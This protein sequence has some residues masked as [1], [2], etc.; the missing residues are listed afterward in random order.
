MPDYQPLDLSRLCNAGLDFIGDD[1]RPAIGIQEFHGLPFLVADDPARCFIAFGGAG[2]NRP[3]VTV[4]VGQTARR[5]LFAHA[6]LE[7]TVLE[8]D[9]VGRVVAGYVVRYA[10]GETLRIEVRERFEI[11]VIPP[12]QGGGRPF[13]AMTDQPESLRRRR[14]DDRWDAAGWR[15]TEA[16]RPNARDY[17]LWA[18]DNPHP[19]R[20]IESIDIVP[21]DRKFLVAAITLAHVDEPPFCRTGRQP[22]TIVL[23]EPEEAAKPF[24]LDVSVDRGVATAPYPL[25][26]ASDEAFLGDDLKGWGEPLNTS[27]SPGYVE[28]AAIPSATITVNN[29]DEEIGRAGWAALQQERVVETPRMR[30]ELVDRGKNWV[31]VTVLDDETGRPVPCRVHFRSPDGIPYQP[32]GFHDHVNSNEG[33]WHVDIGGD[34]RLGQ[35]TYAYIDGTCQGWLPRGEVLVDVARGFEYEPLRTRVS[36]APGQRE[37]T[38]RL[39]RWTDMNA[40]RWFSGDSHVHFLGTQGAHR[41]AQAEDLNVVNLLQSQWGHLFTNTEDWIGRPTTSDDGKTIVY[42]SQENRQHFL[43]HLVLWG[44]Q[45]PVMPWCSDGPDE[46]ELGGTLEEAMAYWADATHAQGGTVVIP[47]LPDPNGEPAALIATGRADAVEMLWISAFNHLE[48]YRYLNCGYRLPLVGGTDKMSSEVPVGLYRTYAHIPDGLPFDYVTWCAAVRA[49]RTFLSSGPLL[50]FTVDG[51]GI[52]DTLRLPGNGGQVEVEALAESIFPIH[53]LQILQQGRVVASTDEPTGARRLHLR[54]TLEVNGHTWLAA[55]CGGPNYTP[56]NHHD[57]WQ[58]GIFAH[59]SPVYVACGG[60][61]WLFDDAAAQYML[62]L[63]E[64]TLAYIGKTAAHHPPGTV[65]HH[66]GE[67]D[68]LACLRRPFHE[69]REALHQRMHDLGVPH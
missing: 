50:R 20:A 56:K 47:H 67:E 17:Y 13:L 43:G 52:G 3:N 30:L 39:R 58:R 35:I 27:A 24:R 55:R 57:V 60:D 2:G 33:S 45:R 51:V 7:S 37:L 49:G 19:D 59:T 53:T 8:G 65:T 11:G 69:A 6:L 23:R 26:E 4:P 22:V 14:D 31:H 40:R 32:H 10:D 34:L 62:T 25:P 61:W 54:T 64:G 41:E 18:W 21:E 12:A 66:H 46:A 15:Q 68:H 44:L 36:I 1:A 28:I 38:L 63:I 16:I 5:V 48:Y 42:C 29:G 9:N